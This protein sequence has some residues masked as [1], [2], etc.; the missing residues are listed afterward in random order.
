MT[1]HKK[2]KDDIKSFKLKHPCKEC[3]FRNDLPEHLMNTQNEAVLFEAISA[4]NAFLD[5]YGD[6]YSTRLKITSHHVEIALYCTASHSYPYK[7]ITQ[8]YRKPESLEK[9]TAN[10]QCFKDAI[11][12]AIERQKDKDK[13]DP[14]LQAKRDA[15]NQPLE[16]N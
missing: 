8:Y 15:N 16:Q 6:K 12:K 2:T 4:A 5:I 3:P 9:L 7:R 14:R 13:W 10:V 1:E 11:T